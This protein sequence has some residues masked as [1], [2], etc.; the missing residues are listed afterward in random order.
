MGSIGTPELIV[1]GVLA[2]L[3]FGPKRL[4]EIGKN[5]GAA[6]REFRRASR[7][8]MSHFSD[9]E[10]PPRVRSVSR[11]SYDYDNGAESYSTPTLD[12]LPDEDEASVAGTSLP[13]DTVPAEA[14]RKP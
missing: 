4:P 11:T 12:A 5:V 2:L 10:P 6:I 7:D 14:E 1:I 13:A 9:D 8:I 3:I